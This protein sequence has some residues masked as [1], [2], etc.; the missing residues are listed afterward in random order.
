MAAALRG[1]SE[2]GA[3]AIRDRAG[4]RDEF[5]EFTDELMESLP[6]HSVAT[7]ER[8]I[9]V[10]DSNVA[11]VNKGMDDVP[12]HRESSFLPTQPDLLAFYCEHPP[13]A[14]GQTTLCDGVRLLT[15]LPEDIRAFV[16]GEVFIWR[17]RMPFERWSVALGTDSQEAA[18]RRI[19]QLMTRFAPLATY[20]YGFDGGYLDG[21]YRAPLVLP[22]LWGRH[23]AFA[24]SL[25]QYY[26]RKPGPLVAK[27]LHHATIS[28]SRI[29]PAEMLAVIQQCAERL[30]YETNWRAGDAVLVDNSRVM[31]G[32]RSFKDELRRI[33]VRLGNY[34]PGTIAM[35][36]PADVS[37]ESIRVP[38]E[39]AVPGA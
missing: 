3:V 15:E 20:A 1:L 33:L 35:H 24:N 23:P 18:S 34:R 12:L 9:V 2:R 17:F 5:V 16:E 6:H 21:T 32:R 36:A 14:G 11:T 29:F 30:L 27:H 31:H 38:G 13:A 26:Y 37:E 10:A 19:G 8:D 28:G 25:L 7:K 4:T 22:T 39:R